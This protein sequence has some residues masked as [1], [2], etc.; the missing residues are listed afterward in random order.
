M[1]SAG[2]AVGVFIVAAVADA[3]A[4]IE[5]SRLDVIHL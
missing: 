1:R 4:A 3:L 5:R 2:L